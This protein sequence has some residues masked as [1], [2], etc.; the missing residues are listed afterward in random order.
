[1]A[2]TKEDSTAVQKWDEDLA[3]MAG[4]AVKEVASRLGGQFISVKPGGI[5]YFGGQQVPG[6]QLAVVASASIFENAYYTD[7]FD[8]DNL[9][10]PV[11]YAFG[12]EDALMV[13]HPSIEH[14][15]A[16]KCSVCP[17]NK[18]PSKEDIR[19]QEAEAKAGRLA[20]VRKGK[21]CK[22]MARIALLPAGTLDGKN[23][24]AELDPEH[25]QSATAA[26]LR[27][28]VT[29][30][31]NWVQHVTAMATLRKRTPAFV[32]SRVWSTPHPKNQSEV[33]FEQL[34]PDVLPSALLPVLMARHQDLQAGIDFPY[35]GSSDPAEEKL[36]AAPGTK[37]KRK[38]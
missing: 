35:Q 19:K 38:F 15:Q 2:K 21:E 18:F 7:G 3:A 9:A 13:P 32:I 28:S 26:F 25:Y 27:V 29:S 5:M 8:P 4:T 6:N 37:K 23:F 11:C 24:E 12:T 36:A 33:H 16:A 10:S 14:P 22:N 34:K 1:M 31:K 17:R 30:V 20:K